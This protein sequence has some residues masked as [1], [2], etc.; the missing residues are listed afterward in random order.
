M[1]NPLLNINFINRIFSIYCGF[2]KSPYFLGPTCL[3]VIEYTNFQDFFLMY[4]IILLHLF[5]F[6]TK[7]IRQ[8]IFKEVSVYLLHI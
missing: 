7:M 2:Y 5:Y 4:H 1:V 8:K 3:L 6:D